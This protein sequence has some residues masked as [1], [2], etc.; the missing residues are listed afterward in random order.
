MFRAVKQAKHFGRH[1]NYRVYDIGTPPEEILGVNLGLYAANTPTTLVAINHPSGAE[2]E[3]PYQIPID[4]NVELVMGKVLVPNPDCHIC[5]TD[6]L[7]KSE[8]R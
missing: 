6:A 7:P 3:R 2:I 5:G 4:A 1:Y 8:W